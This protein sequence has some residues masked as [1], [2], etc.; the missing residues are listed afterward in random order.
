M[1]LSRGYVMTRGGVD[2][3]GQQMRAEAMR[4]GLESVPTSH[5]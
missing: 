3:L 2:A 1:I 5:E 4:H